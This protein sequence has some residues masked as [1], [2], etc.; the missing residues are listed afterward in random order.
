MPRLSKMA[1]ALR[2]YSRQLPDIFNISLLAHL[3]ETGGG[4]AGSAITV[5]G[6]EGEHLSHS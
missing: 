4:E 1:G 3:C 6:V 5:A 2:V